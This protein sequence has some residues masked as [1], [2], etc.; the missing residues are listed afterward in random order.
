V[1]RGELQGTIKRVFEERFQDSFATRSIRD[2]EKTTLIFT[3]VCKD[4]NSF[5]QKDF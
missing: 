4:S 5:S 1:R 2:R 3:S